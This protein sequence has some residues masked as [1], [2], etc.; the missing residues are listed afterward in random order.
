MNDNPLEI[1]TADELASLS[2]MVEGEDDMDMDMDMDEKATTTERQK[3]GGQAASAETGVH[4]IESESD[5][6]KGISFFVFFSS[7]F[8]SQRIR[9]NDANLDFTF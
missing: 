9:D 5:K 6:E 4:I 2:D 3:A 8:V 1:S 7:C